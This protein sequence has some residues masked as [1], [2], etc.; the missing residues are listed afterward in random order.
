[1]G[2]RVQRYDIFLNAEPLAYGKS[3]ERWKIEIAT[4]QA[5]MKN[6]AHCPMEKCR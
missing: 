1:M 6:D 5:I 3:V 2:F 4:N